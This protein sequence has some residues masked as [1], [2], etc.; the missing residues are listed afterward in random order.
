MTAILALVLGFAYG[1]Y[2]A[3]RYQ[4]EFK[5]WQTLVGAII[6]LAAALAT[7]LVM[8]NQARDDQERHRDGLYRKGLAARAQMPDAL[9]ALSGFTA[10]CVKWYDDDRAPSPDH[11][12]EAIDALKNAIEFLESGAA[13]AT[14]ELIS[15]YQVHNARLFSSHRRRRVGPGAADRLFDTTQLRCLAD[16][17]YPY[18][19]NEVETVPGTKP[20]Q[21]QMM[22]ALKV[23]TPPGY[24]SEHE[25]RY[26]RVCELIARRHPDVG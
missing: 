8:Q 23:I 6:A 4:F 7:I 1:D 14:F 13:T 5:D 2:F 25:D 24:E 9:S 17:L 20:T 19:R 15:F 18:A 26:Q 10:E 3:S 22:S 12:T 16:R 11:P 21:R